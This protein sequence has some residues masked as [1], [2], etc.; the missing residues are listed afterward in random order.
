MGCTIEVQSN[1]PFKILS[2]LDFRH[3]LDEL[4]VLLRYIK[5]EQD[6]IVNYLR[7]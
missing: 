4:R 5:G 1:L 6:R 2:M 7:V 3:F